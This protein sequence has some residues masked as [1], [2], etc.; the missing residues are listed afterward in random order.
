MNLKYFKI[1]NP[2]TN[3]FFFHY[4]NHILGTHFDLLPKIIKKLYTINEKKISFLG[5]NFIQINKN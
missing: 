5:L 2:Q 4:I 3:Q 1:I